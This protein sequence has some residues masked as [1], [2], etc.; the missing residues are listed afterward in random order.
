MGKTAVTLPYGFAKAKIT[1]DPWLKPTRRRRETQ[2]HIHVSLDVGG[3]AWDTA[4]NVGTDDSDDL[5]RYRLVYDFHHP[6]IADLSI[7]VPGAT[8]LSALGKLPALDFFRS[9]VLNETGA[10]RMSDPMD[11]SEHPEPVASLMRLLQTAKQT[12]ADVYIFG[13]FYSEG[14]GI[15]DTHMNQGSTGAFIH[16][17]GDDRNDHNDIWQDGGVVVALPPDRWAAYFA[18]FEKQYIPTDDLG[19][20]R[21]D[22][23][24]IGSAP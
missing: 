12:Q 6:M 15:H 17:P 1:A 14:D 7:S 9:D 5:L 20:P 24:A 4:I 2:Y 11:G 23:H 3:A 22:S 16:S 8:D 21:T 13:R 18:A 19:N 10:W